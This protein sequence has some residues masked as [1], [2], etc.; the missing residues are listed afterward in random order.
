[1]SYDNIDLIARRERGI[2]VGYTPDVLN[3][4]TADMAVALLLSVAR[5]VVEGDK[6]AKDPS[7]T[8]INT[9]WFGHQVSTM[10]AGIVGMEMDMQ[11]EEESLDFLILRRD[12]HAA[13]RSMLIM[14]AACSMRQC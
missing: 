4:S 10:T 6:I 13:S 11:K 7:F 3:D 1:M 8:T 12:V 2:R 9:G 14:T 5:R